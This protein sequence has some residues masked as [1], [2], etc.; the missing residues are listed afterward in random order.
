MKQTLISLLAFASFAYAASPASP[1][2]CVLVQ[3]K[4]MNVTWKAYKTPA[5]IGV[6]GRF[7]AVK[8]TPVSLEGRNF[9]E[10]FVGS[11]VNIDTGKI[12]TGNPER[13]EKLVK[14][15]F[16]TMSTNTIEAKI[17]NIKRSDKHEKG[18][19]RTG[20]LSVEISMNGKTETIPMQ[21]I[22]SKGKFNATGTIDLIDF[23]AGKSLASIN[24]ACFDLHKGKTWS[25]VSISFST[26]VEA[27][28]CHTNIAKK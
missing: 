5:K 6:D 7:T 21:Y 3:P 10:L 20:S 12:D 1:S 9:R 18:K 16:A 22:Y 24:K 11:K 19:P 27:T 23:A 4:E 25:D 26:T 2:G 8:Y 14:F 13:D 15:F 28:L 17:V